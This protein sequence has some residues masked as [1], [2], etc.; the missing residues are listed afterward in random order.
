MADDIVEALQEAAEIV[1]TLKKLR[2]L[3]DTQIPNSPFELPDKPGVLVGPSIPPAYFNLM[4]PLS[5]IQPPGPESSGP[6]GRGNGGGSFADGNGGELL[7][8]SFGGDFSGILEG[9][10]QTRDRYQEMIGSIVE[11]N[12]EAAGSITGMFG[13]LVAGS[14]EACVL[15]GESF[16][17]MGNRIFDMA[18]EYAA[19]LGKL[20]ILSSKVFTALRSM[21]PWVA[22]AAGIALM[23]LGKKMRGLAGSVGT[24][25]IE[26]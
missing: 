16:E 21:N 1:E 3:V 6:F 15:T 2:D 8:G 11:G 17:M 24:G 20:S 18:G 19:R 26:G 25:N 4:S 9:I 7:G 14:E 23:V 12:R 22:A 13:Q 10:D 5:F